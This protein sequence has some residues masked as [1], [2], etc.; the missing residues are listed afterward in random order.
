MNESVDV[1]VHLNRDR[2]L[3]LINDDNLVFADDDDIWIEF[4]ALINDV[5]LV[6][7]DDA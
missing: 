7:G 3:R 6:L 5:N 4:L 2:V 1:L